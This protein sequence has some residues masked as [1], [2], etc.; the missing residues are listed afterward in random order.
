MLYLKYN[1]KS[2]SEML[3]NSHI[4]NSLTQMTNKKTFA[5]LLFEGELG[6]GKSTLAQI[7]AREYEA[8]EHNIMDVNCFNFSV[9]EMRSVIDDFI[10]KSSIF[11][12]K[13]A[14]ILDE[15][16]GL[17]PE[18]QQILNKVLDDKTLIGRV[19]VIICTTALTKVS[20]A[21]ISR[22][23]HYRVL[24]LSDEDSKSL[25]DRVCSN[26]G[27]KLSKYVKHMIAEKCGGIPRKM[28]TAIPKLVGIDDK[29]EIG[30]LLD[31]SMIEESQ[32]ILDLFK[33]MF[34]LKSSWE[35][36][37]NNLDKLL[38]QKTPEAIRVGLLDLIGSKLMSKYLKD[39]LEGT[40]LC[41]CHK[42]L[43]LHSGFPE[44]ANI[45]VGIFDSY[46]IYKENIK[47]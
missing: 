40:T 20:P 34:S 9:K 8:D 23:Q 26:E 24:P 38:K 7:I 22:F 42:V 18:A 14:L 39:E 17:S 16:H 25:I 13:K 5:H 19:I 21:L 29:D 30:Y 12:K 3:G 41:E 33:V 45:I 28:L 46:K 43:R 27:I 2:L 4:V 15:I 31:L 11:G 44:K 36:I 32:D 6:C 1:I 37:K 10:N 47:G 35:V